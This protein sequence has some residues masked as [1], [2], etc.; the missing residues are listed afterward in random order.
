MRFGLLKR[1]QYYGVSLI[2]FISKYKLLHESGL[3]QPQTVELKLRASS[4]I[5]CE[6]DGYE[7]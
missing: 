6:K 3:K 4:G 5:K 2:V 7:V 1:T